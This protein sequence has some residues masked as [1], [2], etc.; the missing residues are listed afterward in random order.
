MEIV[1]EHLA[2]VNR[3]SDQIRE[4]VSFVET[5]A[6]DGVAAHVVERE[7]WSQ[8]LKI[9]HQALELFFR[10]C[11]NGDMGAH[12]SA[13]DG[14]SLHRLPEMHGR[15]YLSVFG[16]FELTRHVYGTREGQR[17]EQVPFDSRLQLPES[18]F[19]YLL[20]DWD[21]SLAVQ[22]A[23]VETNKAIARML[24]FEQSVDS[25]E[26]VNRKMSEPVDEFFATQ[27]VPPPAKEGEVVV[28]SA[29]G[30]GV[31]I[32]GENAE[33]QRDG[34]DPTEA[35]K[36]GGKKMAVVGAVYTVDPY[37]RTAEDVLEGLF[38]G[39]SD[40]RSEKPD[41]RPKPQN[42]QVRA[43][44]RRDEADTTAPSVEEIFGWLGKEVQQRN[45][46]GE[47][48]VVVLMDGQKSLWTAAEQYIE[49]AVNGI[50]VVPILDLLHAALYV[51][52][53]AHLFHPKKSPEAFD[54][55]KDRIA[56]I[57][58]GEVLG[59]VRGLR[60]KGTYAG[61]GKKKQKELE[62]ICGYLENNAHRMRYNEYLAAGYPIASGVIE[63]ACRYLVKDRMERTGMRWVL[64]GAHSML[65]LRSVSLSGLW[66]EFTRFRIE[67]ERLR[68]YPNSHAEDTG[69][70]LGLAS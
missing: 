64:D 51:W 43:S 67:K 45:P 23:Y 8:M 33:T 62:A 9:G 44:L 66:D 59:V 31:C 16:L 7:L 55:A 11:G 25:M 47:N 10:S 57:L 41:R 48:E 54:F 24:G 65:A 42:K 34:L 56:R 4:M 60:W 5:S 39:R 53:A 27:S 14:R 20:Q 69:M 58:D 19:S 61:F 18:K 3:M 1:K 50:K 40:D 37:E 35:R 36:P 49:G 17:I 15:P 26:R 30:K 13:S 63:G 21:Q 52:A 6:K 12:I 70:A 22:G 28:V 2:V 68:L 38:R 29:D 32:R 46:L